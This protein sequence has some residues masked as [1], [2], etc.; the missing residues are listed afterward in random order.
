M[1]FDKLAEHQIKKAELEGQFDDLKGAGK[2]LAVGPDTGAEGVGMRIMADEGVL[3]REFQLK[4][5]AEALR[6]RISEVTDEGERKALLK[7][8][9]DIEMRRAIEEEARRKYMRQG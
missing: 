9:A 3:P 7:E 4:K 5:A 2:P 8:L 1:R 6:K